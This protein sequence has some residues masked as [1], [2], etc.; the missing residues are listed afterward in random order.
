MIVAGLTPTALGEGSL[1]AAIRR[2]CDKLTA[3]SGITVRMSAAEDLP[4]LGMATD[5]VLLRAAQEALANIR[6]HALAS[7]VRVELSAADMGV[8]LLLADNG[9]GIAG[10]QPDGFGLRGMKARVAQTGG[11]MTVSGTPGGGFTLEIQV[12]T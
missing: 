10:A 8:R 2:L 1:V 11:T 7:A 12:P 4:T 9:V 3:E 5:V 6:K